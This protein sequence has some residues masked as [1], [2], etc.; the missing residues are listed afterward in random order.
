MLENIEKET[1]LPK[2]AST[3]APVTLNE[4]VQLKSASE[5]GINSF[6]FSPYIE[7]LLAS[8]QDDGIVALYD[9]HLKKQT[10]KFRDHA[11]PVRSLTF[12][13][14]SRLLM[15]SVGEDRAI[16]FYDV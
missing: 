11:A 14:T 1:N 4:I 16:N 12:S 13:Q 3:L 6:E 15:I 8:S 2:G 5:A 9:L 10:H 7:N